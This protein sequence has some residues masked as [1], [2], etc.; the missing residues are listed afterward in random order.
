M[1]FQAAYKSKQL[2]IDLYSPTV[3]DFSQYTTKE[4]WIALSPRRAL[5]LVWL[6]F[7]YKINML[8]A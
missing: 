8:D 6:I 5:E 4:N 3:S 1:N 2:D 7:H